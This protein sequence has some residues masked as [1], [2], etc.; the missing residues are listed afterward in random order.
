MTHLFVGP[1]P[2]D[3]ALSCGGLVAYLL[4]EAGRRVELVTVFSGAGTAPELT[5]YQREALGFGD[6]P[7]DLTPELAMAG[8]RLEDDAYAAISGAHLTALLLPDGVFRGY[9]GEEQLMSAP[10]PDDPAPVEPLRTLISRLAPERVYFPLAVGGHVDHR[11]VRRAG[12]ELA[13]ELGERL[14]FYEDF[15]YMAWR[16]FERLDQLD[17]D[18]LA[19]LPPNFQLE[20]DYFELGDFAECKRRGIGAYASQ[21]PRLFRDGEGEA[22]LTETA[23]RIGALGGKAP[24]ERYWRLAAR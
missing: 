24:S 22:L 9:A 6:G 20:A 15:P 7:A 4:S 16:G 14:T 3:V 5:P 2:D 8:R 1:H 12:V 13:A 17:P 10:R 21:L 19:G 18:A 11:Q 23:A